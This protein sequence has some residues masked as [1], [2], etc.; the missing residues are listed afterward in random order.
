MVGVV[1]GTLKVDGDGK[2]RLPFLMQMIIQ[3]LELLLG[4]QKLIAQDPVLPD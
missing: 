4:F 2:R 3:L 1:A